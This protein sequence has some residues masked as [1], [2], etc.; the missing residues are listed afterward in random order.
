MRPI[1]VKCGREMAKEIAGVLVAELYFK[2]TAIY[3]LCY[4]DFYRCPICQI[5]IIHSFAEKPFWEYHEK[6]RHGQKA[7][8]IEEAKK[9]GIY[10]EVL[11]G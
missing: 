9:K 10:F 1:C 6:E 8:A 4:A 11:E 5:E 3:K 2:N 7:F